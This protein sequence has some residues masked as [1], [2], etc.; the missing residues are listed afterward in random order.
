MHM[1]NGVFPF[2][3]L[4]ELVCRLPKKSSFLCMAWKSGSFLL[5]SSVHF[6]RSIARMVRTRHSTRR[7]S[8]SV[9][10]S[11]CLDGVFLIL[12]TVGAEW[13]WKRRQIA[14]AQNHDV[15]NAS[16]L[17]PVCRNNP[18]WDDITAARTQPVLNHLRIHILLRPTTIAPFPSLL[19]CEAHEQNVGHN[20]CL[21]VQR[22]PAKR[23]QAGVILR[24]AAL[25][26]ALGFWR[27][28]ATGCLADGRGVGDR[29]GWSERFGFGFG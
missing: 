3:H 29:H 11:L 19:N 16:Q 9:S 17:L 27:N 18:A 10:K 28:F 26:V 15:Y 21:S 20:C 2:L 13:K 5:N 12:E 23:G 24:V 1:N 4:Q 8:I 14:R 22:A 25:G 7:G 6:L